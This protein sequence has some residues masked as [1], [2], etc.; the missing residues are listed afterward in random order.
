MNKRVRLT[1]NRETLLRLDETSLRKL[2]GGGGVV[3]TTQE[4]KEPACYSPL[5]G[6][7]FWKTCETQT[8]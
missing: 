5:C 6:P 1:L 7:T 4:T 3:V 8:A 2:D